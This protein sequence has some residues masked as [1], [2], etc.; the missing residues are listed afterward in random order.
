MATLV[1]IPSSFTNQKL[2]HVQG[3]A[4][5]RLLRTLT[6]SS[7]KFRVRAAK[8]P[9]GGFER[10]RFPRLSQSS[11][12]PFSDSPILLRFGILGLA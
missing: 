10:W 7:S 1:T 8:L 12:N 2:L 6:Q 9:A 5:L 3:K 4:K 11:R